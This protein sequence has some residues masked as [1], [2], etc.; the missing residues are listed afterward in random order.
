MVGI[1]VQDGTSKSCPVLIVHQAGC[2]AEW[3]GENLQEELGFP[4]KL[5]REHSE[6]NLSFNS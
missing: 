4:D 1:H 2:Q 3:I 6:Q 5:I